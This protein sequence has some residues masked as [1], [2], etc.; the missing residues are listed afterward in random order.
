MDKLSL[1]LR[2]LDCSYGIHNVC[3]DGNIVSFTVR[4]S[5]IDLYKHILVKF[6]LQN[7]VTDTWSYQD[8]TNIISV[9]INRL[10]IDDVVDNMLSA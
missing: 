6:G 7:D 5:N 10:L 9:N 4:M 2:T 8:C 3:Y 1:F